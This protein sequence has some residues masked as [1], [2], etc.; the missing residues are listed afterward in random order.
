VDIHFKN[1]SRQAITQ[2]A[3]KQGIS[4]ESVEV[5]TITLNPG[6]ALIE[7]FGQPAEPSLYYFNKASNQVSEVK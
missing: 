5:G 4:P 3:T 6:S 7:Q 2:W 1:D